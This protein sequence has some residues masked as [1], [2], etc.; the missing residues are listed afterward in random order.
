MYTLNQIENKLLSQFDIAYSIDPPLLAI[1][2]MQ[3]DELMLLNAQKY[4][5]NQFCI[6]IYEWSKP[7]ITIGISQNKSIFNLEKIEKR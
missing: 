5:I 4:Q 2:N 7:S 1:Q 3:K 6:R